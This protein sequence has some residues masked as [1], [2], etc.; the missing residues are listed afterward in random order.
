MFH[1]VLQSA[2]DPNLKKIQ[3]LPSRST[4]AIHRRKTSKPLHGGVLAPY[5]PNHTCSY[6]PHALLLLLPIQVC[7]FPIP[8]LACS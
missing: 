7:P 5:T 2:G 8:S 4:Q 3:S 1:G 6:L